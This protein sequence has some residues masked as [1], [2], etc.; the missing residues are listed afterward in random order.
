MTRSKASRIRA[1]AVS[2]VPQNQNQANDAIA[3]IGR[4]QRERS[5]IKAEM[6]DELAEVKRRFED[7][8]APYNDRITALSQAV[9]TWAEANRH[10]L[11]A[12]KKK[13]IGMAAGEI[14]WRICPP[15]VGL[16]GVEAVMKALK[17]LGLTKF[18]RTKEEI[19]KDAI[20]ADQKAVAHVKG[21]TISQR[22]DFVIV[23]FETELEEVA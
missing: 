3:E 8:A 1:E 17:E 15:K 22:E 4:A 20:L 6:N 14:K 18:I 12:G 5:R 19:D 9:Q 13:T 16:R 7:Q 21:I 23:P 10:K 11:T 2:L